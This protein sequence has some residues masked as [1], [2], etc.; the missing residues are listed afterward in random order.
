MR[1]TPSL[2]L[3]LISLNNHLLTLHLGQRPGWAVPRQANYNRVISAM[4]WSNSAQFPILPTSQV[5]RPAVSWSDHLLEIE[6]P[7]RDLHESSQQFYWSMVARESSGNVRRI[8]LIMNYHPLLIES[9]QLTSNWQNVIDFSW[10]ILNS[11]L[12]NYKLMWPTR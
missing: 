7:D 8:S 5:G 1:T 10:C 4:G 3:L 12:Q 6:F 2:I 9:A 11:S